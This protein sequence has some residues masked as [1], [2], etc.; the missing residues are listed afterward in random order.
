MS[1]RFRF[2]LLALS[3]CVSMVSITTSHAKTVFVPYQPNVPSPVVQNVSPSAVPTVT[4][5]V[6]TPRSTPSP[7]V[8]GWHAG[9]T[10]MSMVPVG[11]G[12]SDAS[13]DSR[14]AA[15]MG[16]G[17]IVTHPVVRDKAL[18]DNGVNPATQPQLTTGLRDDYRSN[19]S[20]NTAMSLHGNSP[21]GEVSVLDWSYIQS[22]VTPSPAQ[23][24]V[25]LRNQGDVGI[26]FYSGSLIFADK[27]T[28]VIYR[29]P[30]DRMLALHASDIISFSVPSPEGFP[31]QSTQDFAVTA[32]SNTV[33]YDD[34][35]F[36]SHR[37]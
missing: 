37:H 30:V 12:S 31:Q 20:P 6:Q 19:S 33:T 23:L 16:G 21:E 29:V 5:A 35:S 11:A 13:P 25:T 10:T 22:N 4:P 26:K 34:D 14:D 24:R 28:G 9:D 18:P 7:T 1:I 17:M 8:I 36:V 15:Y 3:A 32:L 27:K 2:S